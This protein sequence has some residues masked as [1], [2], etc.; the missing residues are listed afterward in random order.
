MARGSE[1]K[2]ENLS[3]EKLR[4]AKLA[5][6]TKLQETCYQKIK[7]QDERDLASSHVRLKFKTGLEDRLCDFDLRIM[8]V[9][10]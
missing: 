8:S 9:A 10:E 4:P 1:A 6:L 7:Q 3:N 5:I 2:D